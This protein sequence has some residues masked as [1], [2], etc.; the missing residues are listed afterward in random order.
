MKTI[1]ESIDTRYGSDS[2]PAYSNGNTLPYTGVPF[3]MNYFTPQT[4]DN[5]GAWFFNPN[6]PI[7]QGIRLTHQPSPWIG[8][9]A[10]LLLTPVSEK[11]RETDLFHRQSSYQLNEAIFHPHYLK[12]HSTRY[13]ITSE[14]TA[15]TYGA[16]LTFKQEHGKNIALILHSEKHA[17]LKKDNNYQ[18][19][20]TIHQKTPT[21]K[22]DLT[23]FFSMKSSHPISTIEQIGEDWY[24]QFETSHLEIKLG[25]SYLSELQAQVN[26]P[27][28]SFD[29]LKKASKKAWETYLHRF[30]IVDEGDCDRK[31]FDH[32]LYRLFL[33]PQTFYE[34]DQSGKDQHI[35]LLTGK[36]RPGKLFTNI[37]FWDLYRTSFPLYSLILSDKYPDFLEGFL[38]SYEETG[39][40]P[41]WLAPDERGMM[42]G[43]LIDGVLADACV[44]EIA[45]QLEKR[46]LSAMVDTATKEDPLQIHGRQGL[47]QYQQ[48]GYLSKDH[49]ESV[50]HTLDYFCIATVAQKLEETTIA[51]HYLRQSKNYR[52][53]YNPKTG[54]MQGKLANGNFSLDF[55]PTR[56]GSDYAECSA[57]QATL[58]VPHDIDGLKEL[59]G[60]PEAFTHYLETLCKS[61]ANF[62]TLGYGYEIHEMSEMATAPFAQV[63]ISNQP[64]FHIPYLFQH[65]LS[66]HFTS[67]LVKTIREQAFQANFQAYP[68]DE[69]NG[70]LS[71]WYIWS[72]LGLYPSC[73]GKPIYQL[74]IPLFNH[75]KF[76]LPEKNHWIHI[77]AHRNLPHHFFVSRCTADEKCIQSISHQELL[78]TKQIEFTLS[79]IP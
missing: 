46:I 61:P 71:A 44:K 72:A 9:Y 19:N 62:E 77:R 18:L 16:I 41:K 42:P 21:T 37:G 58:A 23:F 49:H 1:V 31:L 79:W 27:V 47:E 76:Y 45:P 20:G 66:S 10:W 12:L 53:L 55:S 14:V 50:S 13:Q 26:L 8:D 35:N 38:N 4:T 70:S 69:D 7:Y 15:N 57:I 63:A 6:L 51:K 11:P 5:Q 36:I 29:E 68:E 22:L 73:P 78:E 2:H 60:G 39:F 48:F 32:C 43:T 67:L 28:E 65:S 52:H 24:L 17:Q 25:T 74:G 64:S 34:V 54:Y 59:M 40:L 75:I 33:F 56:W 30:D 3:G